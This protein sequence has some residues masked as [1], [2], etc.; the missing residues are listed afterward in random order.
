[1]VNVAA[2]KSRLSARVTSHDL[3]LSGPVLWAKARSFKDRKHGD[4][5]IRRK[6]VF[7][8]NGN[9]HLAKKT[10]GARRALGARAI[11]L[12]RDR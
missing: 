6:K 7:G 3:R 12:C 5:T 10:W 2:I 1:M 8:T 11:D 9:T 4:K